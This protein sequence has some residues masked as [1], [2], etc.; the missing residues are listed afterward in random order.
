MCWGEPWHLTDT[1]IINHLSSYLFLNQHQTHQ[2]RIIWR[3]C[4]LLANKLN[5]LGDHKFTVVLWA[6]PN[7]KTFLKM[8][9]KPSRL[10]WLSKCVFCS[11]SGFLIH[12]IWKYTIIQVN[13]CSKHVYHR[14]VNCTD[15]VTCRQW[16]GCSCYV[17]TAEQW[18]TVRN[19]G[20]TSSVFG[21]LFCGDECYWILLLDH[22][23]VH[24]SPLVPV[25][26]AVLVNRVYQAD[27]T[28]KDD[29]T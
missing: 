10:K 11:H 14:V 21:V 1:I 13:Q 23:F 12:I 18:K 24:V 20:V 6:C 15:E 9:L 17:T 16:V 4:L 28:H 29:V 7:M 22:L 25:H 2:N 8:K 27:L 19:V 5:K 3:F 26:P